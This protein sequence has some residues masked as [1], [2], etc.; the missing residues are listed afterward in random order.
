MWIHNIRLALRHLQRQPGVA[1][2]HVFGLA[3]GLASCMLLALYVVDEY[4]TDRFHPDIERIYRIVQGPY[5]EALPAEAGTPPPLAAQL[6]IDLPAFEALTRW[7]VREETP[8]R[9]ADRLFLEPKFH[10]ADPDFFKVFRMPLLSGDPATALM[11]PQT[12]IITE[13]MAR[14]YFGD[15]DPIGQTV[16]ANVFFDFANFE[17]TGIVADPPANTRLAF[18]FLGSTSS[19]P[20]GLNF[21]MWHASMVETY[22]KVHASAN[23]ATLQ[24]D[25]DTLVER[26]VAPHMVANDEYSSTAAYLASG[27]APRFY[28]QPLAAIHL[29][30]PLRGERVPTGNW[31]YLI[32][33]S[34]IAVLI[35]VLAGINFI[36]L[37]LAQA[38]RRVQEVGVRKALGAQRA[39]LA[40]QFLTET[41]LVCLMALG[42]AFLVSSLLLP[43][44][45]QLAAKQLSFEAVDWGWV[46]GG[47]ACL[48]GS[49]VLL[50]G[51][52]P[53]LYLAR[54]SPQK[55]WHPTRSHRRNSQHMLL[56]F[57][58]ALVLLLL[59][60]SGTIYRQVTYM[61]AKDLGFDSASTLVVERT[62]TLG[63]EGGAIY[64][65]GLLARADVQAAA[66][67]RQVP[68]NWEGGEIAIRP[69][70]K[71]DEVISLNRVTANSD[72]TDVL[73]LHVLEGRGF[74][75][76]F[77]GDSLGVVLNQTAVRALGLSDPIGQRLHVDPA[78]S[79]TFHVVGVV[80][81]FHFGSLHDA[82]APLLIQPE[83]GGY[84]GS[85]LLVRVQTADLATTLEA[86]ETGWR[87]LVPDEPFSFYFLDDQ[88]ALQYAGEQRIGILVR[89]FTLLALLIGGLGLYG[90]AAFSVS[91][92]AKEIGIRK[93]LGASVAHIAGLFV[94]HYGRLVM[95]ACL[96]VLP[97]AYLLSEHWLNGFAYRIA[98][99]TNLFLGFSVAVLVWAVGIVGIHAFRAARIN[100]VETLRSE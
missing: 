3:L 51:G 48:I 36:N 9:Y 71:P 82:I 53:A 76:T 38:M 10:F 42:V 14:K 25:L 16:Y 46:V 50:A 49:L 40:Q 65:D 15:V 44:V 29:D 54:L 74:D 83:D 19:L 90:L 95:I 23:V 66:Y 41:V 52:Y 75:A 27:E 73:G 61:L 26:V 13:S 98:S 58:F 22:A 39:Q 84:Q 62:W 68:G 47:A 55:T 59:M 32:V 12:V 99:P 30:S 57:Q 94:G 69:A 43:F 79:V 64:R 18:N 81:D 24:E 97:L 56:M 37:S 8:V 85:N 100:P 45:N 35:L 78:P 7:F 6:R 96:F 11:R 20:G 21:P 91:Q 92:R 80:E 1:A 89:V 93:A 88:V 33:F 60:G 67:M 17:V 87:A 2:I 77:Q 70:E 63:V 4:Q 34:A 31:L 5:G 86:I 28:M 72:F